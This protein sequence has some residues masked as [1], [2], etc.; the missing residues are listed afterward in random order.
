VLAASAST[1]APAWAQS[2]GPSAPPANI[3]PAQPTVSGILVA[4]PVRGEGNIPAICRDRDQAAVSAAVMQQRG[5]VICTE[6]GR[7]VLLQ[8]SAR[9]G[10]Y[11]R[12]WGRYSV[13]RLIDGDHINAWGVLRDRGYLLDPTYAVQDT[14]LQEAFTDSQDFIARSGPRLTLYVL[15]SAAG[16]PVQGIVYAVRGGRTHITLCNGQPGTWADLTAGKTIDIT[17]SLF[18]RRLMTYIHTDT[19]QVVSCP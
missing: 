17:R 7:L 14:D 15:K 13:A 3:N 4:K 8:L 12:Y 1:G 19:V 6:E 16:G 10:I 5:L 18:N 9:T 2:V 11:A